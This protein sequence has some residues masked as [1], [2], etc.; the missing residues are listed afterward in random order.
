MAVL[1]EIEFED[2]LNAR[3]VFDNEDGGRHANLLE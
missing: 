1:A 2:F 3:F